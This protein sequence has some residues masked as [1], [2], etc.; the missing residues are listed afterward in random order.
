MSAPTPNLEDRYL[1]AIF[2]LAIGDGIGEATESCHGCAPIGRDIFVPSVWAQ[3]PNPHHLKPDTS[4]A[5]CLAESLVKNGFDP[6]DQIKRY[7]KWYKEGYLSSTGRCFDIGNQTKAAILRMSWMRKPLMDPPEDASIE[8]GNG[9]IMRL[10]P[11]PLAFAH[12]PSRAVLLS[13]ES[14][15]TTHS[16]RACVDA[17]R[18]LGALIVG[19]L[20]GRSKEEILDAHFDPTPGSL[21]QPPLHPT[22]SLVREGLYKRHDPPTRHEGPT[23]G[24]LVHTLRVALW[25]FWRGS[26]FE[27]GC[28]LCVNV[29]GFASHSFLTPRIPARIRGCG[30]DHGV[31]QGMT[32]WVEIWP[33]VGLVWPWVGLVWPWVGM[34]MGWNGHVWPWIG[35]AM[36]WVGMT[37]DLGPELLANL[38]R[39]LLRVR[40]QAETPPPP[41][42]A[43]TATT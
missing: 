28:L 14:S 36:D 12:D 15:R 27:E 11:V 4:M 7:R 35:L 3:F 16:T 21:G 20:Q 34:T 19:A 13:G 30:H 10:A 29:P 24:L 40:T 38:A 25:A 2:G 5:L 22:I 8:G 26:S 32:M 23:L 1:G 43:S 6:L 33:W 37:Y 39:Q 18:Y 42:A 9:S 31:A 17:C 41:P